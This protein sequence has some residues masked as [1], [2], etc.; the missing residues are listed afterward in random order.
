M[1]DPTKYKRK[2]TKDEM[3]Q[4]RRASD[5]GAVG[6]AVVGGYG[7]YKSVKGAKRVHQSVGQGKQAYKEHR[8]AAKIPGSNETIG[9]HSRTKSLG[10][11]AKTTMGA[12][13]RLPKSRAGLAE[14][15]GGYVGFVGGT[16]IGGALG[17]RAALKQ[18]NRKKEPVGKARAMSDTEIRRRKKIQS[19]SS[20]ITGALGLAALGGTM[21]ASRP[22]RTALR[23]I[24]ALKGKVAA[25]KPKDPERDRIKAATV[26][27]LATSA[28]IGGASAFNFASYTNAESK[29]R[30]VNKAWSAQARNFDSEKNRQRRADIYPGAATA[31]SGGAAL[32][33]G[34][35][36]AQGIKAKKAG[37]AAKSKKK[38][39]KALHTSANKNFKAAGKLGAAGAALGAGALAL[40]HK[41]K[42]DS[43]D[44]YK[45]LGATGEISKALS[46]DEIEDSAFGEPS[47]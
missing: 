43:W 19:R 26:P 23:K 3:R 32:A 8:M 21:A 22:G 12:A 44:V 5:A 36:T 1:A 35:K 2:Y 38:A 28:G 30:Q 13:R 47:E 37:D 11:A 45:G 29:K 14:L 27:V 41:R 20:Q 7:G 24:P 34:V 42:S 4:R 39:Y 18:M 31:A 25:P 46:H 6:G 15:G 9:G 33:A 40:E 17:E 10:S 16:V